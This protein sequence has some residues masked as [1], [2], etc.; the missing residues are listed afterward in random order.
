[1]NARFL[2]LG[3]GASGGVPLIGCHCSVCTSNSLLNK[4]LRSAGLITVG[5]KKYLI[6]VGPDFRQQALKH[7]IERLDGVL[8]THAHADHIAGIDDLR[9]YYFLEKKKLPCLLSQETFD[10]IQQRFLYLFLSIE[11]KSTP[12]QLDFYL[13]ENDFGQML[14]EGLSL[15]YLS[16][17]QQQMKVTG[18]R[19][20]NFAY[21]SD[22]RTYSDAVFHGLRGVEIL[23][24]SALRLHPTDMHFSIE[25]AIAFSRKAGAKITYFTHIAHDLDHESAYALLPMD[26]HLS[27]DGLEIEIVI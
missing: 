13:L 4:R 14:F 5:E 2:F 10:E 17:F 16:Y 1:M 24:L 22:I 26:F 25:E 12:A 8:I 11:G 9:A 7:R 19:V 20:G 18:F 21:V 23:V 15:S 6:D 27:H 3:T